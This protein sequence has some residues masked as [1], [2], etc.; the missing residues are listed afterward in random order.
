MTPRGRPVVDAYTRE[1][2]RSFH[3]GIVIILFVLLAF[4]GVVSV[5]FF[6]SYEDRTAEREAFLAGPPTHNGTVVDIEM[7]GFGGVAETIIYMDNCTVVLDGRHSEFVIGHTYQLWVEDGQLRKYE[8]VCM[9]G[10]ETT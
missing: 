7:A 8:E 10:S 4:A 1:D 9:Y 3:V 5:A 2:L 6:V